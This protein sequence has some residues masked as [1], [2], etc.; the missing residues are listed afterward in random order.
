[1][2]AKIFVSPLHVV[3]ELVATENITHVVS[4]L[5]S[6]NQHPLLPMLE[7]GRHLRLTLNDLAAPVAGMVTPGAEHVLKLMDFVRE[8]DRQG[9][10]L[11]HCWAGISRST[12]SAYIAKCM[13]EP[14]GDEEKLAA[15]LRDLSPMATPNPMLVAH[16]DN[17]MGRGGRMIAAIADIGRGS[18]AFEGQVF[19]WPC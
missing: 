16:G 18:Y 8:W 3:A 5:G 7:A 4:L 1:M 14:E 17:I 2:S 9:N 6:D 19:A 11:I 12:A 13:Y 10:M 15:Q